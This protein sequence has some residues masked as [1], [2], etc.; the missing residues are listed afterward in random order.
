[1]FA[2]AN[3]KKHTYTKIDEGAGLSLYQ[4]VIRSIFHLLFFLPIAILTSCVEGEEEVWINDDASGHVVVHYEIPSIALTQ[5]GDPDEFIRAIQLIDEK[6]D[7]IEI[8][9]LAFK[10]K[11]GRAIFHLEAKFTDVREILSLSERNKPFFAKETGTD[12]DK[13]DSIMGDIN[14]RLDG[15]T[16]A[17]D[18]EVSPKQIFPSAVARRPKMLGS[19]AFIYTIHMP[20]R[21]KET[22]AHSIS[23]DGKTVRWAFKLRDHFENPIKMSL[24]AELPVPWFLWLIPIL[25]IISIAGLI[26]KLRQRKKA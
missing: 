17:F 6:E 11:S 10:A 8:T 22:N 21:V 16:P 23:D 5:L 2:D 19:A 14:F 24:R 12:P 20:T 26:W 25:A 7:L 3:K 4:C 9:E 13:L 1:M 18:R 15:L